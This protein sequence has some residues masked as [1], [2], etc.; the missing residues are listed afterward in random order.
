MFRDHDY[1]DQ[2]SL[3]TIA[4]ADKPG[5]FIFNDWHE[6]WGKH[7][8]FKCDAN[9]HQAEAF[10]QVYGKKAEGT[11]RINSEYPPDGF[12]WDSQIRI[13][14]AFQPGVHFMEQYAHALAELDACRITRGGLFLDK[15]HNADLR[16]FALAYRALPAEKFQT[17]SSLTDP[18]AVRT[19]SRDGKRYFYLQNRDYYPVTVGLDFTGSAGDVTELSGDEPIKCCD[20][21]E[22]VIGPYGLRSFSMK[23]DVNIST[24]TATAPA[25]IVESIYVEAAHVLESIQATAASGKYVSGMDDFADRIS[26]LWGSGRIAWLRRAVTSY[27]ARKCERIASA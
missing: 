7:K 19:L 18:V 11:F 23:P 12:W 26:W 5:V 3:D 13:T 8:W 21:L 9:D 16:K 15:A 10:A 24:F 14:H 4:A 22:L 25:E 1:L 17:V 20:S 2:D 27:I 6:A